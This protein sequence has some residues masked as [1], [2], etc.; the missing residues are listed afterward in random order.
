MSSKSC[1]Y[2]FHI[3]HVLELDHQQLDKYVYEKKVQEKW[4]IIS[5]FVSWQESVKYNT[6]QASDLFA[7]RPQS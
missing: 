6:V 7:H 2:A 5:D 1:N 4:K 3:C